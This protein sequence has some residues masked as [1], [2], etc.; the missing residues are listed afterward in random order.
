MLK[1]GSS[2]YPEVTSSDEWERDLRNMKEVGLSVIRILDFAW[3]AIEP[4]EGEYAFEWLDDFLDLSRRIGLDVILCTPTATPPAWLAKQYPEIMVERRNGARCPFG[5]RRHVCVNSPIY[6]HFSEEVA[7]KLGERYGQHPAVIGWQIDNELIG[8]EHEPPECHCPEC[9]WQFRVWLKRKFSSVSELNEAWGTGY[10]NQAFGDWGEVGT[11]RHERSVMGHVLDYAR[12][13]NES[14]VEYMSVQYRALKSVV[15]E[16]QFV[17]HNS[18]GVF[19]R[20]LNHLDFARALDVGAWDAYRGAAGRPFPEAFAALAHDLFR[21]AKGTPFLVLETNSND[22]MNA[23]HWVEMRAHGAT[24]AIFWHWRCIPYGAEDRSDT[25]CDYSGKPHPDRMKKIRTF[26]SKI[27][28]DADLSESLPRR[29]AAI[30]YSALCVQAQQ[31]QAKPWSNRDRKPFSYLNALIKSYQPFWQRGV[32]MDVVEPGED[33][34]NYRLVVAPALTLMSREHAEV[35]LRFVNDGGVLLACARTAHKDLFGKYYLNPGAPM[36]EVLGVT[37]VKPAFEAQSVRLQ[38]G[39]EFPVED[40]A[41]GVELSGAE[42][43]GSFV[44]DG[45]ESLPAVTLNRVGKGVVI[46][47]ACV[48][49]P[50]IAALSELAIEEADLDFVR[51]PHP[52]L[53]IIPHLT[54]EG[55][56]YINHGKET[57]EIDGTTIPAEDYAFV[58]AR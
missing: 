1:M 43:L 31:R 35:L 24:T 34:S 30:I 52:Q 23:A 40:E 6:R 2:Y 50:L 16:R 56:W 8:P 12:F 54:G 21:S 47:M 9:H 13:F 37:V 7:R 55:C 27:S 51:N 33:L 4:R 38:D 32:P 3:T 29:Q 48:S 5:A 58:T 25:L 22:L 10:W 15:A 53:S 57:V 45:R 11:P 36:R 44:V 49:H 18:T 19:D 28:N 39:R 46:Y 42:S 20:S 26:V 14:Q 17:T 41:E